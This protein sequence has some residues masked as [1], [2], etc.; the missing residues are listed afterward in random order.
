MSCLFYAPSSLTTDYRANPLGIHHPAPRFA[1]KLRGDQR[2]VLQSAFQVVAA[3]SEQLLENGP[4]LWDSGRVESDENAA[5]YAG[6]RLTSRLRVYWKVCVWDQNGASS[7]WSAPA[8]FEMGLLEPSDWSAVW[9]GAPESIAAP[10]FRKNWRLEKPVRSARVYISG[11]GFY[12]LYING[13]PVG[14]HKLAPDRTE[15]TKTVFYH[16]HDVTGCMRDGQNA[17]GVWLGNGWYNQRDKVNEKLLWYGYPRLI[18]QLELQYKD[19]TTETICSG[20]DFRI[21]A[22]PITYNNIY[23]GEVYDASLELRDWSAPDYDDSGWEKALPVPAPGGALRCQLAYSGKEC[24]TLPVRNIS[25]PRRGIYVV[26]FGQNMVGWVRA[27]LRGEK[28]TQIRMRFGEELWPDGMI[29]YYSTG[30]GWKP[31]RD[32][33]IHGGTGDETYE[34]RFTWHGFRYMEISG[35]DYKPEHGDFTAVYVHNAVPEHGSFSCSNAL[36]NQIQS[37]CRWTMLS[38]MQCGVPMDSPH[39]ERQGYGGDALAIAEASMYNYDMELFF[40]SWMDDFAD[41]QREDG[42]IPHTVPCQDGGGGP[43]WGCAYIIIPWML[44]EHYGD[45]RV[46]ESHYSGMERWMGFLATGVRDGIVVAEGQDADCL[47]EWS[48]PGE[49]LVS[50]AIVNTYFYGYSAAV[51]AKIAGVLGKADDKQRYEALAAETRQAF[52]QAFLHKET[53]R[54]GEG[55]QGSNAFAWGFDAIPEELLEKSISDLAKYV[56]QDCDSHLDTGIFGTPLLLETLARNGHADLAF[57]IATQTTY[58]SYGFMLSKGATA[59]WEYW[60]EIHGHCRGSCCHNQPMFGSIS[61]KFYSLIAG[62][63]PLAPSWRHIEVAPQMLGDLRFASART[64][65]PYGPLAVDWDRTGDT[66]RMT[67][68]IPCGATARVELPLGESVLEGGVPADRAA[69]VREIRKD[70]DR[71]VAEIGSGVYSFTVHGCGGCC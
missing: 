65:T 45:R 54:Y 21:S 4:Y 25:E 5:V 14:D 31:Q 62:L 57:R 39:R 32:V 28:G 49:T 1:W 26:D 44:Y 38:G 67:V 40:S 51:M 16:I 3:D 43:A 27:T 64:E 2:G 24:E 15:Y 53:G 20:D 52:N 11:I 46:L 48:T 12:E 7:P 23:Y 6:L 19:G 70:G 60:E 10:H 56:E 50:P 63:R 30:C 13:E 22:G 36:L 37:A 35:I 71:M 58:P 59:L 61:G 68:E 47:G 29:D 8:S 34:P 42:F 18:C 9:I 66:F 69:G 33:Y 55:V 17:L 41:A